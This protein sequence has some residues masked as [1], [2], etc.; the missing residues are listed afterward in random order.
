MES[1]IPYFEKLMIDY[2]LD[3]DQT[4]HAA[5][6]KIGLPVEEAII[7]LAK[8]AAAESPGLNW[9][10]KPLA[11]LSNYIVREH[12]AYTRIQI[13]KINVLL[14]E[15]ALVHGFSNPQLL[16]LKNLFLEMGGETRSH[17]SREEEM[18]FPYLAH[19]E[20]AEEDH[21]ALPNPF[22]ESPFFRQ[23]ARILQWEHRMTGEEW[24][25]V[26]ML[27]DN[28][29]LHEKAGEDLR[30]LYLALEELEMDLRR[31]VHLENNI[32]FKRAVEKGWVL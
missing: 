16:M 32:L 29:R 3:G 11:D 20:K 22:A 1:S 31:H 12:H 2:T 27:T 21:Q 28:Y 30:K 17:M 7:A 9:E 26:R 6:G 13:A 5:C 24:V 19:R 25:Q 4:L 8:I 15:A 18:L 23:P 10:A 14:R